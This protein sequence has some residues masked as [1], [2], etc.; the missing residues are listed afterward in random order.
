MKGVALA[1]EAPNECGKAPSIVYVT[2]PA[3]VDLGGGWSDTPPI[4]YEHCNGGM[5]ANIAVRVDGRHPIGCLARKMDESAVVVHLLSLSDASHTWQRDSFRF[6]SPDDFVDISDPSLPACLVRAC[7]VATNFVS[8]IVAN[9]VE[10][11]C[12]SYLPAGKAPACVVE[13]PLV[14]GVVQGLDLG[15]AASWQ[16]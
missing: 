10:I 7:C 9:G 16:A 13:L 2:A 4:S 11:L 3:R 15:Q 14:I 5:V 1:P 8:D 12:F 6:E